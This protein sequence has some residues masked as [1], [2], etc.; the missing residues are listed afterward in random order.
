MNETNLAAWLIFGGFALFWLYFLP[1]WIAEWRRNPQRLAITILNLFLGWTF[2]GWVGALVWACVATPKPPANMIAAPNKDALTANLANLN[3][4]HSEGIITNEELN[5]QR[6]EVIRQIAATPEISKS[7]PFDIERLLE[8]NKINLH[9]VHFVA[10]G[11]VVFIATIYLFVTSLYLT[12]HSKTRADDEALSGVTYYSEAPDA[13]L[14]T[15][16]RPSENIPAA[17][18]DCR[19]AATRV[20]NLICVSEELRS[21]DRQMANAYTRLLSTSDSHSAPPLRES[22]RDWLR[23]VR[24]RCADQVCLATAYKVRIAELE[25]HGN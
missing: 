24:N 9:P 17:S 16:S 2:V 4:L 18:F 20:E 1:T 8:R 14:S 21:M 10:A 13:S 23:N 6:A 15:P 3:R 19:A 25:S 7:P 5:T 22:Q 12:S 11:G